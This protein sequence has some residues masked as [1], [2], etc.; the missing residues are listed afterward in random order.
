[1]T[2]REEDPE[3]IQTSSVS[4]DLEVGSGALQL[5]G[6]TNAHNSAADFS[7]QTLEPCF[8]KRAAVFR[9]TWLSRI[10]SPSAV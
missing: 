5:E 1:M 7:N 2:A 9:T 3:S 10:G 8:S 4:E 6:L